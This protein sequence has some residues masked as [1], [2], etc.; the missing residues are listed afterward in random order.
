MPS[1][2]SQRLL[3]Y[4]A[5][6]AA[7]DL[8]RREGL[9]AGNLGAIMGPASGPKWLVLVGLDRALMAS[10][11]L[12]G[13]A[14]EAGRRPLLAGSSAGAW[15]MLTLASPDP[16]TTHRGLLDGY[17]GQVFHRHDTPETISA[18][19]RDMLRDLFP[20]EAIAHLV[21]HPRLDLGIHVARVRGRLARRRS[22]QAVQ[23]ATA[24]A[25]NL[26]SSRT[27]GWFFER[28]FLVADP[29]RLPSDFRG[30]VAR[31]GR[32]NLLPAARATGAVPIYLDSVDSIPGLRP[33]VY[34]DGGVTDY[35]LDQ[36]YLDEGEWTVEI[37]DHHYPATV[38][39]EPVGSF[40]APMHEG[41]LDG[42]PD[43]DFSWVC[44]ML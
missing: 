12:D 21:D 4:R 8:L 41:L 32:D 14:Q 27:M 15:R 24:A 34:V 35:H 19:Y 23:L 16:A 28:M 25:A 2:A 11:L 37:A 1:N 42:P 33:G 43:R 39:L 5:G 29:G 3:R 30:G 10:G 22:A 20:D 36:R 18:A 38:S 7:L 26:V 40:D 9:H 31:L 17:V 44:R 6:S 13:E